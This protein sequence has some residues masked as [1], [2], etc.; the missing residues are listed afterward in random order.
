[1]PDEP[2]Q[3]LARKKIEPE[4]AVINRKIHKERKVC[5]EDHIEKV[6]KKNSAAF[7]AEHCPPDAENIVGCPGGRAGRKKDEKTDKLR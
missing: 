3:R 4:L 5:Q 2:A 6:L 7:R 1:M